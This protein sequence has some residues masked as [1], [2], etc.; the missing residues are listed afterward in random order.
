MNKTWCIYLNVAV[1]FQERD[2]KSSFEYIYQKTLEQ[3]NPYDQLKGHGTAKVHTL[4]VVS[5]T[6][7]ALWGGEIRPPPSVSLLQLLNGL[8]QAPQIS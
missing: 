6:L 4:L 3:I 8:Q 2:K 7:K 5:L 1:W